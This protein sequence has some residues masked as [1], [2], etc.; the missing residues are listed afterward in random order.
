MLQFNPKIDIDDSDRC[1][2]GYKF[3][4]CNIL[5]PRLKNGFPCSWWHF[6]PQANATDF[7]SKFHEI[8]GNQYTIKIIPQ[9]D[10]IVVKKP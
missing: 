8:T 7:I 9:Y 2:H 4:S 6:S 5:R 10:F 1:W 3:G